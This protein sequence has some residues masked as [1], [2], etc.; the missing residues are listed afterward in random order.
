LWL[1]T[2]GAQAPCFRGRG[3]PVST[4]DERQS[5]EDETYEQA[6]EFIDDEHGNA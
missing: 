3:N 6:R 2:G 5:R 1:G 4:S